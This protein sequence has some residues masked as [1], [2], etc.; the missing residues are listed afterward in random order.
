[1]DV[2]AAAAIVTACLILQADGHVVA[3]CEY[4]ADRR[5]RGNDVPYAAR[6]LDEC[7]PNAVVVAAARVAVDLYQATPP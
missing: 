5:G 3:G 4:G 6:S 7:D 1:M 2:Q